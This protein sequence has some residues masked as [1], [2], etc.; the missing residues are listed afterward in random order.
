MLRKLTK[1]VFLVVSLAAAQHVGAFTLWGPLEL[2]Q[3]ADLDYGLRFYYQNIDIGTR[4]GYQENGGPKNFGEGSRL[5]VPVVTYGFDDTFLEYFGAQGVAA[6][7]S[8]MLLLNALP[9]ADSA[10]LNNFLTDG[11]E[12][13]N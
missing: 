6:V 1:S 4:L 12:Q 13:I 8:A 9:T 2:W 3:T 7:D 5:T 10:N 11:A